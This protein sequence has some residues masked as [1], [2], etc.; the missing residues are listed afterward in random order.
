MKS[1]VFSM[2]IPKYSL[3][4]IFL[5]KDHEFLDGV[6]DWQLPIL[7]YTPPSLSLSIYHQNLSAEQVLFTGIKIIIKI[8]YK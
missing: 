8:F 5:F 3:K 1:V 7:C 2:V 6:K 4:S